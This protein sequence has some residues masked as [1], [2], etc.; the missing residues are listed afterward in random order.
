M[1]IGFD[2]KVLISELGDKV[3]I[4]QHLRDTLEV[5]FAGVESESH[6]ESLLKSVLEK[7]EFLAVH[8]PGK[9]SLNTL[10]LLKKC[11]N[12]GGLRLLFSLWRLHCSTL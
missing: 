4:T 5:N 2:L 6:V 12:R 8:D 7:L 1:F 10:I 3:G 11:E 9:L